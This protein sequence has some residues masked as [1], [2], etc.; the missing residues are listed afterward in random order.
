M[1]YPWVDVPARTLLP[2]DTIAQVAI[3]FYIITS[4]RTLRS[5]I[6][7]SPMFIVVIKVV[8]VIHS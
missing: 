4:G 2:G 6:V 7:S 8:E 3:N 5:Q 1:G